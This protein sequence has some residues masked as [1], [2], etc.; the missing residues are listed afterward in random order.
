MRLVGKTTYDVWTLE[1]IPVFFQLQIGMASE[2]GP[3]QT[4]QNDETKH[5]IKADGLLIMVLVLLDG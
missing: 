3:L 5:S 4:S 2:V 1:D